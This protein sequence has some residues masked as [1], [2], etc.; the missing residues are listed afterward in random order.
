MFSVDARRLFEQFNA[1][2]L[3]ASS[4]EVVG[5]SVISPQTGDEHVAILARLESSRVE[6][7]LVCLD[8]VVAATTIVQVF[9]RL[10]F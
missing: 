9:E 7:A 5:V 1:P 8:V 10:R 3:V 6:A 4:R 2:R